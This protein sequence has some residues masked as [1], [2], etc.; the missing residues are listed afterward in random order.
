MFCQIAELPGMGHADISN[1][2]HDNEKA[3]SSASFS[4]TGV[5]DPQRDSRSSDRRR[6]ASVSGM[7][8]TFGGT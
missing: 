8:Q 3:L 1:S 2:E 7:V 5:I 4:S 6:A